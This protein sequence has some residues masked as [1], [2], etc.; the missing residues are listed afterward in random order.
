MTKASVYSIDGKEAG[1][2]DLPKNFDEKIRPDLIKRA[3]IADQTQY[4]QPKGTDPRAGCKTSAKYRGRKDDFGSIK[5]HGIAM[6]PKEVLAKGRFGRVR[7][8]P[9]AVSGR[10]AHPP[11]IEKVLIERINKKEY[12]KA[13]NSAIAATANVE[14]VKKRGHKFADSVKLPIIV[15][16]KADA[17]SKTKDV[18]KML[19]AIGL[20]DELARADKAR[21]RTGVGARG[22]SKKRA[23]SVLVVVADSKSKL[24][25]AA[26]NIAGVDAVTVQDLRVLDL[27]P[28]A[29]GVRLAVYTQAALEAIAKKE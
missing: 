3:V 21:P 26:E 27:A 8:I 18:E 4:Y 13:L 19:L 12:A 16:S 25:K 29:Q 9:S 14:L 23:K 15:D 10:R 28:G 24:Y 20:K 5:N 11:K 6:L 7:R 22:S 2:V 17:L 1:T